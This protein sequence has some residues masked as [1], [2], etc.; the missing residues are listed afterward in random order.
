MRTGWVSHRRLASAW[1]NLARHVTRVLKRAVESLDDAEARRVVDEAA[2]EHSRL[3][4]HRRGI[5]GKGALLKAG[6][7]RVPYNMHLRKTLAS[8]PAADISCFL[9]L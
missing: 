5:K 9:G 2:M 1:T 8:N 4:T 3:L 6:L 7:F